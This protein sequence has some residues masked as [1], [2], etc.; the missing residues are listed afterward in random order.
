MFFFGETKKVIITLHYS[1]SLLLITTEVIGLHVR[2]V[3]RVCSKKRKRHGHLRRTMAR[4][5][6]EK[7]Y[8]RYQSCA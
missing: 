2:L 8:D 1:G 3:R 5:R 4:S 7:R 6:R